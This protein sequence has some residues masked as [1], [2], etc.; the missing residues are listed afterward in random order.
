MKPVY[1]YHSGLREIVTRA[2]VAKGQKKYRQRHILQTDYRADAVLGYTCKN[3]V[4]SAQPQSDVVEIKGRYDIHIWYS[5]DDGQQTAVMKDCVHYTEYVPVVNLDGS[6]LG[7][8]EVVDVICMREPAAVDAYIKS[9]Y[10]ICV[11]VEMMFHAEVIGDARLWVRVYDP[12]VLWDEKKYLEGD[13][14]YDFE[15]EDSEEFELE[16]PTS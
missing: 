8:N 9:P 3:H 7:S 15:F 2:A 10:E 16:E 1:D 5:F 13:D 4:Y 11:V 14:T 12:P 6:R